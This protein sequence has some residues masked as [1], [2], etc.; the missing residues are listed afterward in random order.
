TETMATEG[1][2]YGPKAENLAGMFIDRKVGLAG[3]FGAEKK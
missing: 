1:K 3:S 2:F